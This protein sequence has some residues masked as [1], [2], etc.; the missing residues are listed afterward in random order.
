MTID[1]DLAQL[2]ELKSRFSYMFSSPHAGIDIYRGWLP[3]FIEAC[4]A[5]D[6]LLCDDKK[7]FHFSQCKEKYGWA[8]Y[9]F[10]SDGVRI[11]KISMRFKD[12][13]REITSGLDGH[14]IEKQITKILNDAE[15]KSMTKCIVCGAPAE[16]RTYGR[17]ECCA[18]EKHSPDAPD[19]QLKN[20]LVR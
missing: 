10:L 5:I 11:N 16:I 13:I 15:E 8:R 20:A 12:G 6:T 9:Y 19:D 1:K 7:G 18:C 4:E 17:F 2:N 14:A 3:D